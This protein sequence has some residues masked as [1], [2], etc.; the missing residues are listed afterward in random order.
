MRALIAAILLCIF[1][2][3]CTMLYSRQYE[4]ASAQEMSPAEKQ[5]VF[6]AFREYLISKGLSPLSHGE[7]ADPNSVAFRIG[8]SLAGFA[9]RRDFEDILQLTYSEKDGFRLQLIR[10][11]HQRADFSDEYLKSFVKQTENFI[12]EATS[13]PISLKIIP[14]VA[15]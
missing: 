14:A 4:V 9:L 8:G 11:V 15:P 3:A 13:K 1:L 10:I 12:R 6:V 2:S 7:K 5:A